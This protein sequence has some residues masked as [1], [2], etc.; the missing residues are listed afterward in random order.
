MIQDGNLQVV[1]AIGKSGLFL[2]MEIIKK[3]SYLIVILLFVLFTDKPEHLAIACIVNTCIATLVNTFPNRKLI[4]YKYR[5]QI[6]D[7][8]P[9]L[10]MSIIMGVTVYLVGLINLPNIALIFIQVVDGI[11][12]YILLCLITKNKTF[13]YCLRTAKE[14]LKKNSQKESLNENNQENS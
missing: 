2:I 10:V 4:G 6:I 14:Y 8:L 5:L 13:Y 1:R 3:S 11:I 7:L 12:V 9:N